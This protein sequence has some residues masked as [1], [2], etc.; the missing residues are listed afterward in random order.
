MTLEQKR[1]RPHP[2]GVDDFYIPGYEHLGMAPIE[3]G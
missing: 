2:G 1:I 3:D